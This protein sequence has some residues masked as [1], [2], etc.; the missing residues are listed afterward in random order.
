MG[1]M[2]TPMKLDVTEADRLTLERWI[3]SRAVGPKVKLRARIVLMTAEGRPTEDLMQV[4]KVSH[5]TL[6]LWRRR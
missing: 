3:N 5:P 1:G 4:L 2:R 6:N